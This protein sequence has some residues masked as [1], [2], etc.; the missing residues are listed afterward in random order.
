MFL[1]LNFLILWLLH[2]IKTNLAIWRIFRIWY[3]FLSKFFGYFKKPKQTLR[4]D[5]KSQ[6]LEF[7][8]YYDKYTYEWHQSCHDKWINYKFWGKIDVVK[9]KSNDATGMSIGFYRDTCDQKTSLVNINKVYLTRG[10]FARHLWDILYLFSLVTFSGHA[11][12]YQ[13]LSTYQ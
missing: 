5:G 1:A 4:F 3:F 6:L 13:I 7:D 8:S 9:V 2:K 10:G 11:Y 12:L